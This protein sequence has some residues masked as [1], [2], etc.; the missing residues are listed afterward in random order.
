MNTILKESPWVTIYFNIVTKETSIAY[1][2]A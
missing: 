2:R 1:K